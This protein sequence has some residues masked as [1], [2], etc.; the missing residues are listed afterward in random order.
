M[1]DV[2]NLINQ[3][4]NHITQQSTQHSQTQQ[5][6]SISDHEIQATGYLYLELAKIYGRK[7][8]SAFPDEL[9]IKESKR[10]WYQQIGEFSREQI[11]E[12]LAKLKTE[13]IKGNYE[14]CDVPDIIGLIKGG[15]DDWQ[16]KG[17]AYKKFEDQEA[18]PHLALPRD[19]QRDR[20]SD[21]RKR[22]KL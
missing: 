8:T 11:D 7:F 17:L 21:L 13:R 4:S 10:T 19:E 14:W 2:T 12:G 9:S 18:L 16:H 15:N 22:L 20:I 6:Q 1:K 3:A 5:R